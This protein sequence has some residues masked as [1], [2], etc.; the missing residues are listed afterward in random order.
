M[1]SQ[2][3]SKKTFGTRWRCSHCNV[4]IREKDVKCWN[5][6][7]EFENA[8]KVPFEF[9]GK[10]GEYFKI[11]IVN[12]FLTILTLG[13]YSAWAKVRKNRYFYGNTLLNNASFEYLADPIRILKGRLIVFGIFV[14]YA[15]ATNIF[16]P[17]EALSGLLFLAI[18]PWLVIK[19]RTFRSRNSSYRNIRFD[20]RAKYGEAFGVFFGLPILVGLTMGLAYPYFVFRKAKFI[21]NHSG[22]GTSPFAFSGSAKSF[23]AI[24][25]KAGL[26][27]IA[28]FVLTGLIFMGIFQSGI[29]SNITNLTPDKPAVALSM[30]MGA[31]LFLITVLLFYLPAI[32]YLQTSIKNLVWSN[33]LSGN[34]RFKS[35]LKTYSMF[36]LYLSNGLA[37]MMSLG[38]LIPW[39]S[40]R[41]ARYKL[42]NLKLFAAD[43]LDGFVAHEQEKVTSTGEEMS[44]FFDVDVGI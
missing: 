4:F 26:L 10:T 11:W 13:I 40:I 34:S 32:A 37:I 38:F 41:M 24:Y 3:A 6:G 23:Y 8:N 22:Y 33:T 35:T 5:C 31:L 15:T 43:E 19:A 30:L 16:P 27:F 20:F 21:V 17:I 14:V 7:A 25:L 2:S 39:A 1:A 29:Q 9:T 18:L 44:D 36:W 28:F 12:I 42:D